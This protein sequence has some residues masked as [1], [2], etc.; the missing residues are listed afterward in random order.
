MA[1]PKDWLEHGY[2]FSQSD[3]YYIFKHSITGRL[4][5]QLS[6]DFKILDCY[7]FK[8]NITDEEREYLCLK[9]K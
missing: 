7:N 4:I 1:L 8:F 2:I 3:N 5:G 9:M 6:I